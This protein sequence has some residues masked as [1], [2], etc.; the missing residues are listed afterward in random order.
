MTA[1]TLRRGGFSSSGPGG[2]GSALSF[3]YPAQ[4]VS[5]KRLLGGLVVLKGWM[6]SGEQVRVDECD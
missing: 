1:V 6:R 4:Q 5:R 2:A 3:V